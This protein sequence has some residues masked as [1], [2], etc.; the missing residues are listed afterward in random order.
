[1]RFSV[2]Q[3]AILF[4]SQS[5]RSAFSPEKYPNPIAVG[6]KCAAISKFVIDPT[7]RNRA[8]SELLFRKYRLRHVLL[9][10]AR[11]R[12]FVHDA[13]LAA[14]D[15]P[16]VS[17]HASDQPVRVSGQW[18]SRVRFEFGRDRVRVDLVR[19][20]E[21]DYVCGIHAKNNYFSQVIN[22]RDDETVGGEGGG[23]KRNVRK[24]SRR[25]I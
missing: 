24:K 8:H 22:E 20:A 17:V 21:S 7:I 13:V 12:R 25:I 19:A 16:G 15:Q 9:F 1:M 3:T 23:R 5:I 18:E 4:V 14:T 2:F 11:Q 6:S 10:D